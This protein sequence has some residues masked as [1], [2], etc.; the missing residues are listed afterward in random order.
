MLVTVRYVSLRTNVAC[1][2]ANFPVPAPPPFPTWVFLCVLH[3]FL[4]HFLP[5]KGAWHTGH[6][7]SLSIDRLQCVHR[8]SHAGEKRSEAS[9][10]LPLRPPALAA[11]CLV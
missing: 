11:V 6:R 1:P 4:K 5:Q 3:A 10:P 7:V 8:A 9:F 2:H